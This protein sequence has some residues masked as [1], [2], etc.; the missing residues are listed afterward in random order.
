MS[1]KKK[2]IARTSGRTHS[3]VPHQ[4]TIKPRLQRAQGRPCNPV[5]GPAAS[6]VRDEGNKQLPPRTEIQRIKKSRAQGEGCVGKGLLV[7]ARAV[8]HTVLKAYKKYC[9]NGI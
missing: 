8:T 9:Y 4:Q 7:S 3:K 5:D 6:P 1:R 2:A